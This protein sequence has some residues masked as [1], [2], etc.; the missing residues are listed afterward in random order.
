MTRH[1]RPCW[2]LASRR[3]WRAALRRELR[4]ADRERRELVRRE[5]GADALS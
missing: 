2:R 4:E 3:G 5:G 1:E